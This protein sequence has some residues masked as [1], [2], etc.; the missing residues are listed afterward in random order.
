MGLSSVSGPG[1]PDRPDGTLAE[2]LMQIL[3][4]RHLMPPHVVPALASFIPGVPV[5]PG[6]GL[7]S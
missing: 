5:P 3:L 6:W 4:G 2:W 1:T 7:S